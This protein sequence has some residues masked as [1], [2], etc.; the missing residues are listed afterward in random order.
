[1]T[2]YLDLHWAS[3]D[4]QEEFLRQEQQV[5]ENGFEEMINRLRDAEI[6]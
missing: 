3:P 1:M 2:N 4:P 6:N 5:V